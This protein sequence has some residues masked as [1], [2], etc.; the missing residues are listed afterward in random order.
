MRDGQLLGVERFVYFS[1]SLPPPSRA[2]HRNTKSSRARQLRA[3][4]L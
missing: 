1:P 3:V 2:G 4:Q